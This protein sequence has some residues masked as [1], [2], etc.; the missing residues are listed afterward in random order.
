MFDIKFLMTG[1]K[2]LEKGTS[3]VPLSVSTADYKFFSAYTRSTATSGDSRNHYLKHYIK[4]AG[5]SGETL[6]AYTVV[7]TVA[8]ATAHG[9]HAS[10][11]FVNSGSL[12]GLGVAGRNTFE[13]PDAAMASGGTFAAVMAEIYSNG[14]SSDPSSATRLSFFRVVNDGHATG[15]G[16][17]EDFANFVEIVGC[18]AGDDK[19]LRTNTTTATHSLRAIIDGTR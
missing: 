6:R 16:K 1:K 8:G 9:Y 18:A 5:G 3:A 13:I 4:G 14:A 10:L 7:D 2:A 11:A 17:V 15:V 19:M 12:T